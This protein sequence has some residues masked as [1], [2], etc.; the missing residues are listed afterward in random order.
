[1]A[2]DSPDFR[3]I[4]ERYASVVHARCRSILKSDDDA[5]DAV[6][7]IFM[8]LHKSLDEIKNKDSIYCWLMSASTNYCISALRRRKHEE[9]NEDYHSSAEGTAPQ[10]RALNVKRAISKYL[11]PWDKKVR[12]AVWYACVDGYTSDETAKLTGLGESTVR[13]YISEF[14]KA[15]SKRRAED[16]V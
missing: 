6:Q 11:M 5:W 9:F 3:G 12:E 14:R 4:Y 13:K 10:E 15:N 2:A 16:E 1:M 8:K 7:E